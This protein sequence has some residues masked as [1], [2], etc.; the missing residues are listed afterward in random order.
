MKTNRMI[1]TLVVLLCMVSMLVFSGEK[2]KVYASGLVFVVLNTYEQTMN[3]G[4]EYRL[5][6]VTSNGKKPT[7]CSSD[8]K[9]ASVNTYGLI[10]A[11]K[12]GTVKIIVRT[13]NGEARCRVTVN[14]T[15][16]KL[17]QQSVSL[18]NGNEFRLKADVSTGHEV[19]YKSSKRSVAAVDE[20]GLIT[21]KKPGDALI[22]VSADGTNVTCRVKVRQPNVTLSQGKAALYRKEV[23][24]LTVHTNS[25]TKPKWKSNRSGVATVDDRGYVTAVKHGTA[26]ITVTVD[27]VCKTCEVVVRQPKVQLS[28]SSV[29]LR[30]GQQTQAEASVSSGNTPTYSSSN[31]SIATVEEDGKITAV[32]KGKAYIYATEDGIKAKLTVV[33]K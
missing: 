4:D 3:I 9:I 5:Y 8:S 29:Q 18:D 13:K 32:S 30:V 17:N 1:R 25:K 6:A 20:S 21:A 2:T 33:V 27:G 23:L 12:A 11:K 24:R 16:I 19:R 28:K 22:T 14:K 7:F 31:T 26:M 15:T 10:T